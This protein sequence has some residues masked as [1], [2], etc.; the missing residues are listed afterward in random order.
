MMLLFYCCVTGNRAQHEHPGQLEPHGPFL[1]TMH[2]YWHAFLMPPVQLM[3][4]RTHESND[5]GRQVVT[6]FTD[7]RLL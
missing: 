2:E 3:S 5:P 4:C 1:F 7:G 6:R